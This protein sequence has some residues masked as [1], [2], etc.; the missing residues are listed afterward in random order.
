MK[1]GAG[2]AIALPCRLM[3]ST[4]THASLSIIE[5]IGGAR[6]GGH[7][8]RNSVAKPLERHGDVFEDREA[9]P[10]GRIALKGAISLRA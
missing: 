3:L 4:E 7:A 10:A 1:F 8:M 9:L 5:R 2:G 6:L